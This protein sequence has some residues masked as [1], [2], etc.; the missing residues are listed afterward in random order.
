M[1]ATV[2]REGQFDTRAE[3]WFGALQKANR[4]RM[5]RVQLKRDIRAGT[6]SAADYLLDPPEFIE[7]MPID[8]LLDAIPR[9]GD[10]RIRKLLGPLGISTSRPIGKLTLR[11]C[12]LIAEAIR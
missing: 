2:T 4:V 8:E 7:A 3:Q 5:L 10:V 9:W 6:A 1:A 11:Q 12:M